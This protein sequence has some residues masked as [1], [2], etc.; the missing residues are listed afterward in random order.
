MNDDLL[1]KQIHDLGVQLRYVRV[2]LRQDDESVGARGFDLNG[3]RLGFE[4][5]DLSLSQLTEA[6][7]GMSL[8]RIP[9]LSVIFR[10]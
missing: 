8:L 6:L 5:Y 3:F 2:F 9:S 10:F 7:A 4:R 1:K